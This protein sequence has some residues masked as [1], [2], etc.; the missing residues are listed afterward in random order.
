MSFHVIAG[1]KSKHISR[2]LSWIWFS[3]F[4]SSTFCR[5]FV[6]QTSFFFFLFF[7]GDTQWI[8][9]RSEDISVARQQAR[10]LLSYWLRPA[11]FSYHFTITKRPQLLELQLSVSDLQVVSPQC[12]WQLAVLNVS[13]EHRSA[14]PT[15]PSLSLSLFLSRVSN[16]I[17]LHRSL[18]PAKNF[19]P[20]STHLPLL[21]TFFFLF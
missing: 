21:V 9:Y 19:P 5:A 12:D 6:K 13:P 15:N 1:T 10:R 20:V 14:P 3:W 18:P 16:L 7:F 4:P 11:G 17:C 2:I 8:T